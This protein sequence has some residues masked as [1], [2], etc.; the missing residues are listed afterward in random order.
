MNDPI[1]HC[2]VTMKCTAM[3]QLT[4]KPA[5]STNS[6]PVTGS[7]TV[8]TL[9]IEDSLF[10]VPIENVVSLSK[11]INHIQELPIKSPGLIGVSHY[12]GSVIPVIDIARRIGVKSGNDVKREMVEILTAREQDHIDWLDSLEK[13]ISTG[14]KFTRA[15]DPHQCAFG[16]WYDNFETRN[17]ALK[18]I[19]VQFDVPHQ[20]IHSL[21]DKLLSMREHGETDN[22]LR[23]LEFQRMTTLKRLRSLFSHARSQLQEMMRPILLYVTHDGQQ[24]AFALLIDE[25]HDAL[26][27][28]L[29]YFH[30]PAKSGYS[31]LMGNDDYI[32]GVFSD[33]KQPR[34][35]LLN[36]ARLLGT[37]HPVVVEA[38][39]VD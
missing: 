31:S 8:M 6:V 22:A 27:Y 5:K 29:K 34:C 26:T 4:E 32:K 1:K 3:N 37:D 7:I 15:R 39:P 38:S 14:E 2:N 24:P 23:E 9:Y 30:D 25:V 21:A 18:E 10:A 28:D 20:Q 12:L 33:P 17:E 35:V 19:L 36:I 13:S 11:E 16:K